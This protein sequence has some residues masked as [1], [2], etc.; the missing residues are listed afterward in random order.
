MKDTIWITGMGLTT[1]YGVGNDTFSEQYNSDETSIK[2]LTIFE[3]GNYQRD[4]AAEVR[5][6]DPAKVLGRRGMRN[7]D[8][9]TKLL[10]VASEILHQNL[11]FEDLEKRREHFDDNEVSIS[12]GTLGSIKSIFDFDMDTIKQPEYVQPGLFP[13]T[14]YCAPAS[15]AAIRRGVK[16]AC[17]T[18]NN[19]E[20]SSLYAFDCG[21]G[22]LRTG[23]AKQA[24]VGATEEI[25][26]IYALALQKIHESRGRR[27][28]ILGEGAGLFSLELAETA[29]ARGAKPLAEVLAVS[30][31][32]CPDKQDGYENNIKRL[33]AQVGES[34]MAE[35]DHMMSA[36][37]RDLDEEAPLTASPTKHKLYPKLGFLNGLTGAMAVAAALVDE[38]IEA[39]SLILINN[40]SEEGNHASLLIRK[41]AA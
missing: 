14:V 13:N 23:R 2:A 41:L 12:V 8:R 38:D 30:T 26:E 34:V 28:P 31:C 11:G 19:D 4:T 15:Y 9:A 7:Y 24:I 36:Q 5:D 35:I 32:Y 22:H 1:A 3:N 10:M 40:A 16:E 20:P 17:V 18:I 21:M 25:S 33:S 27:G 37:K 6:F 29:E 39:G